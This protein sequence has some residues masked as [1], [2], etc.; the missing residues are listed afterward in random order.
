MRVNEGS[1]DSCE[2]FSQNE[3]LLPLIMHIRKEVKIT[4]LPGCEYNYSFSRNMRQRILLERRD[5]RKT[6]LLRTGRS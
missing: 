2:N 5:S 6:D 4:D 3:L 1:R